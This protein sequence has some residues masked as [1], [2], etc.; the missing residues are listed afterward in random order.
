MYNKRYQ[1]GE[2]TVVLSAFA[3]QNLANIPPPTTVP[4][5]VLLG[6]ELDVSMSRTDALG[7]FAPG[8]TNAWATEKH[9]H[10]YG[11]PPPKKV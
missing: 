4:Q 1:T 8:R 3:S 6:G 7:D 11:T 2:S 9:T 5:W 10:L